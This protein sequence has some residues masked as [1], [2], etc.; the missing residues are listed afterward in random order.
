M[1]GRR[2]LKGFLDTFLMRYDTASNVNV[3]LTARDIAQIELYF[4]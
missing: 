2:E 4:I 3:N 1:T